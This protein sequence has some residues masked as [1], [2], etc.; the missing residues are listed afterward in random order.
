MAASAPQ[1]LQIFGERCSGTNYVAQLLRRNLWGLS[2]TDEY[3]WKHGFADRVVDAAERCAFVLVVRDPFDWVRSLQR[4][5][6]HAAGPL[7]GAPMAR[8]LREP[9]WCEWGRDMELPAEDPRIG[10]EMLHERDPATGQR[11][12]NVM[13]LR[14]GK[15]RDWLTLAHRVR[16]FVVVRY[17]DAVADD[18]GVVAAVA[19]A[20]QTR[21]L[22]WHRPV[23]TFKGGAAPYVPREHEELGEEDRAWVVAQLDPSLERQLG[24]ELGDNISRCASPAR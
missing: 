5:P 14:S 8:F 7:R 6:W 20:L 22:P 3:G 21:R 4:R 17:E 12:A 11:F 24:Y 13:Q 23:R 18:R 2:L 19:A 1:R 9:W 16:H 15:L 10:T